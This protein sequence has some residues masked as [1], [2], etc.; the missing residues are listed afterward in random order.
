MRLLKQVTPVSKHEGL[1]WSYAST[2][3]RAIDSLS[4]RSAGAWH[5][6]ESQTDELPTFV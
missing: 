1:L 5:E 2:K 4:K 3:R 6:A